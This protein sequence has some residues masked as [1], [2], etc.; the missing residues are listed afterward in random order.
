MDKQQ[1]IHQ[2]VGKLHDS[3]VACPHFPHDAHPIEEPEGEGEDKDEEK[4]DSTKDE[5]PRHGGFGL[6]EEHGQ[7]A[8]HQNQQLE[9]K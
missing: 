6:T 7:C 8:Q 2:A 1:A 3:V 5:N 9:C 4:H